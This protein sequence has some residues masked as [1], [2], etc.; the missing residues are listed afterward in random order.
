MTSWKSYDIVL[1]ST[2]QRVSASHLQNLVILHQNLAKAG[3]SSTCKEHGR[4]PLGV[5]EHPEGTQDSLDLKLMDKKRFWIFDDP[6]FNSKL[7][8]KKNAK[9]FRTHTTYNVMCIPKTRQRPHHHLRWQVYHSTVV[10]DHLGM[11]IWDIVWPL[12]AHLGHT[13]DTPKEI[14][15]SSISGSLYFYKTGYWLHYLYK[16]RCS[17]RFLTRSLIFIKT[18]QQR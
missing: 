12:F 18:D 4:I 15:G 3:A 5:W 14:V 11:E 8:F 1:H 17:F 7:W 9:Y 10:S 13:K 2:S 6:Q 16:R